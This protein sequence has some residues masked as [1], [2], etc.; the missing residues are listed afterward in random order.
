MY[1]CMCL[2][3]INVQGCVS[4]YS[5]SLSLPLFSPPPSLPT[6]SFTS[7]F[8]PLLFSP[9]FSSPAPF[10]FCPSG[11]PPAQPPPV[12]LPQYPS[13]Y[14]LPFLQYSFLFTSIIVLD[15]SVT[16]TA[17]QTTCV[18]LRQNNIKHNKADRNYTLFPA[19]E[20]HYCGNRDQI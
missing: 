16:P 14:S 4:L 10:F 12:Q 20:W 17:N 1:T 5:P 7:P 2:V 6:G 15:S 13:P 18:F 19:F 11:N 3:F 8:K 9:S